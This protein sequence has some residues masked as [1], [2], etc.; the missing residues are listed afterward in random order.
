MKSSTKK[1]PSKV[2][3]ADGKGV[4]FQDEPDEES[5]KS[6]EIHLSG[7]DWES[8]LAD[9][10]KYNSAIKLL[11]SATLTASNTDSGS[12]AEGSSRRRSQLGE[13][14]PLWLQFDEYSRQRKEFHNEM[15]MLSRLRH[16]CITT[17]MGAVI[18]PRVDPML[19][20]EFME[21]GSLYVS[22]L[23]SIKVSEAVRCR[24]SHFATDLFRT[25]QD[26]LRNETMYAG[27]EILL[28]II[29]DITQGRVHRRL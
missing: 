7:Q 24:V 18:A 26:L 21:Y 9:D 5:Q 2:K 27:G 16:P 28:Q 20:M 6:Q 23:G 4:S 29:R 19:V 22:G 13:I 11:E 17:V 14:L 10:R 8:Y 15:R 1:R 25:S 12:Y 3:D